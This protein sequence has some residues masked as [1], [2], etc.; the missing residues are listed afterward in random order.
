VVNSR[1]EFKLFM[2]SLS[3]FT[4]VGWKFHWYTFETLPHSRTEGG[5]C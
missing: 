2:I 5:N 1:A 4:I 3:V